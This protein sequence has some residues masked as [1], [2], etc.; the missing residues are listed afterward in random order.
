M[1]CPFYFAV[2]MSA[3]FKQTNHVM[4]IAVVGEMCQFP[5]HLKNQT[6]IVQICI[7]T[8]TIINE[9]DFVI[10]RFMIR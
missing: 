2:Q 4:I 6:S 10:T 7:Q 5:G 9:S 3:L 1:Y 8:R